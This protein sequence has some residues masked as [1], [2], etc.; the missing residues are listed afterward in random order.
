MWGTG[1][2]KPL[3]Q[4]VETEEQ[5]KQKELTFDRYGISIEKQGRTVRAS[6]FNETFNRSTKE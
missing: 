6:A 1:E 3:W 2:K 5:K 4:W